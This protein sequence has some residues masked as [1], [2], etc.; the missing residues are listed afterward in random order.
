MAQ[1]TPQDRKT[2]SDEHF[3]FTVA[4]KKHKLPF[5]TEAAANLIPGGVTMDA[6]LEPDNET[7]QLRLA[8]V[9]LQAVKPA[10]AALTALRSLGTPEM[11]EVVGA[12][13]GE[14]GRSSGSSE[15]TVE[16]SSTTS[17]PGSE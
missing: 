5:I 7:V 12:W 10:P 8:L 15:T 11:L 14:S 9:T 17:G 3:T 1:K 2:K 4:G 16:P 6:V 13:M